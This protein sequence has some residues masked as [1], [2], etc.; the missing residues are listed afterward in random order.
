ML[1]VDS[2]QRAVH[3]RDGAG[4]VSES[5]LLELGVSSQAMFMGCST[6]QNY[7][8]YTIKVQKHSHQFWYD[9]RFEALVAVGQQKQWL[10]CG[11][12][13]SETLDFEV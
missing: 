8:S 11:Y 5:S 10:E 4:I 6:G 9:L 1:P 3:I 2:A 13:V 7:V 12:K